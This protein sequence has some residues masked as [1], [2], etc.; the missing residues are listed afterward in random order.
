M[1]IYVL[2]I[3]NLINISR[4]WINISRVLK[5]HKN[6]SAFKIIKTEILDL[7]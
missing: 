1:D 3:Y 7:I 4:S 2:Y 6:L 5:A